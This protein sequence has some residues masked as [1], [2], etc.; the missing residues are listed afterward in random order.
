MFR[1]D[2]K[3]IS[4]LSSHAAL[5]QTSVPC[6]VRAETRDEFLG[7]KISGPQKEGTVMFFS[8]KFA[9]RQKCFEFLNPTFLCVCLKLAETTFSSLTAVAAFNEKKSLSKSCIFISN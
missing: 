6:H 7:P 1:V 2:D 9:S 5:G 3:L 8:R 4:Q